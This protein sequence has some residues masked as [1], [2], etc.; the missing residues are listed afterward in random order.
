MPRMP[1]W[2]AP[3]D[4]AKALEEGDGYWEDERWSPVLLTVMAGTELEGKVIPVAWQL[5][6]DPSDEEFEAAN[7]K[8]EEIQIDPDG[9]G[10]GEFIRKAVGKNDPAL[11]RRLHLDDCET[12]T[13]VI[14]V[15]SEEDCRVLVESTWNLIFNE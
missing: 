4:I 13:C 12:D 11:A 7:A 10:W 2:K 8:L 14:W 9:Y 15:E 5:E 6:F 3:K 1:K